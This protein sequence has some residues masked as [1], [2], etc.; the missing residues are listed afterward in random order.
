MRRAALL[1]L[2]TMPACAPLRSEPLPEMGPPEYGVV[3]AVRHLN[4]RSEETSWERG[5]WATLSLN[6]V[7]IGAAVLAHEDELG[8]SQISEYDLELVPSG[9]AVVRSRYIAEIGQCVMIRRGTGAEYVIVVRQEAEVCESG[10][11]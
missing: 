2:L 1:A 5:A 6:P 8:R 4:L 11:S 9:R 3:T 10:A 7:M